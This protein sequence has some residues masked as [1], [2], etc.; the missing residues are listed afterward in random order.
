MWQNCLTKTTAAMRI[1]FAVELNEQELPVFQ[2]LIDEPGL[3]DK[4]LKTAEAVHNPAGLPDNKY[5]IIKNSSGPHKLFIKDIVYLHGNGHSVI[6]HYLDS[7][8]LIR[9]HGS[10]KYLKQFIELVKD[11]GFYF[12]H[13]S[14]YANPLHCTVHPRLTHLEL[15]VKDATL[16]IP[17]AKGRRK[18]FTPPLA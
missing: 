9:H 1:L 16:R 6:V 4:V 12:P 2:R 11:H 18:S 5:I 10:G 14:Y 15:T 3:V 7:K 8:G 13:Q 17:I